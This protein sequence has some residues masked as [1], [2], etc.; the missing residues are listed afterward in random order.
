MGVGQLL[1]AAGSTWVG[2]VGHPGEEQLMQPRDFVGTDAEAR[3][4][5]WPSRQLGRMTKVNSDMAQAKA[6]KRE[7]KALRNRKKLSM[8]RPTCVIVGPKP[9]RPSASNLQGP[10]P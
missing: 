9:R 1:Q 5:I 3:R 8:V 7:A 4:R 10:W 2:R 6:R